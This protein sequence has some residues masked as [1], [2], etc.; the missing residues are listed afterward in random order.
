[1]KEWPAAERTGRGRWR[2]HHVTINGRSMIGRPRKTRH[3]DERDTRGKRPRD[4]MA[5]GHRAA[6]A[7]RAGP[8]AL[9]SPVVAAVTMEGAVGRL[10]AKVWRRAMVLGSPGDPVS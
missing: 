4:G 5:M 3:D 7:A 9:R 8:D 6:V 10:R 1:G 2:V